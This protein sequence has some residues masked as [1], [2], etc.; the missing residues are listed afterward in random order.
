MIENMY[1]VPKIQWAKW[2]NPARAMFNLLYNKMR[3]NQELFKHPQT[4]SIP[5]PQW[6]T[7]AWN[8]AWTAADM[9]SAVDILAPQP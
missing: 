4:S 8:A 7:I 3:L 5:V 6:E 1:E 9:L 2:S